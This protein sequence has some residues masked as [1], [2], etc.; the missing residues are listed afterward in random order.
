MRSESHLEF[1]L[2]DVVG[3]FMSFY[4]CITP[5]SYGAYQLVR[6]QQ[7]ILPMVVLHNLELLLYRLET[8]IDIH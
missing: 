5:I 2:A 6:S 1:I 3:F 7:D 4:I 8:V